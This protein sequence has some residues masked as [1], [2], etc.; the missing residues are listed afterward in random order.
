MGD[1]INHQLSLLGEDTME[2]VI[3]EVDITVEVMEEDMVSL[4][5]EV[6]VEAITVEVTTDYSQKLHV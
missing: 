4:S 6:M 3:M 2:A 5:S 1:I